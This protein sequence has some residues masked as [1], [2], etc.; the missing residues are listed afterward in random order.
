MGLHWT[1]HPASLIIGTRGLPALYAH[2]GSRVTWSVPV[3]SHMHLLGAM[4]L[5]PGMW[6]LAASDGVF[7]SVSAIDQGAEI[8]L[9]GQLVDP[10]HVPGD[11]RWVPLDV[12]LSRFTGRTIELR[13][14]TE[15][16]APGQPANAAYDW[17]LW[18]APRI[19]IVR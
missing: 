4:A 18:G 2:A 3:Q 11:Q 12:N 16:S 7:F 15:P 17:A 13:L 9:F 8:E 14:A 1:F 10:A 6:P 5:D 19:E